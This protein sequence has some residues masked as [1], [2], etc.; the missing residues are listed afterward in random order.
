MGCVVQEHGTDL[1]GNGSQLTHRIGEEHVTPADNEHGGPA[2]PGDS[3]HAL[4]VDLEIIPGH[5][6]VAD[7]EATKIRNGPGVISHVCAAVH[8]LHEQHVAGPGEA[9]EYDRVGHCR[10]RRPPFDE[11]G[12]EQVPRLR[13]DEC[14]ELVRVLVLRAQRETPVSGRTFRDTSGEIG[15][16]QPPRAVGDRALGSIQVEA[17]MTAHSARV[18]RPAALSDPQRAM[19]WSRRPVAR[20]AR[21]IG[22]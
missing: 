4:H 19:D 14:L 13:D 10:A 21:D 8:G 3:T 22:D 6:H 12:S 17:C 7:V 9:D 2:L 11:L 1:I 5:R 18:R 16:E 15:V 20:R